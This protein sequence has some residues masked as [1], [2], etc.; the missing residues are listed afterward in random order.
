MGFIVITIDGMGS[1]LRSKAF[2]DVSYKNLGDIGAADHILAI[3]QLAQNRPYMDIEKVGI[4]GHSAG[5]YDAAHALLTHPEFYKVA[6]SIAG[7]H[8][9]MM[10]KAWWDEQYMGLPGKHY[11]E[12]SNLTL[13][14]NLQ[15]K[16]FS[17]TGDMDQNVNPA[18]TIRFAGELIKHNKD[19][20]LLIVPNADHDILYNPYVVRKMWDY[21][22]INLLKNNPPKEFNIKM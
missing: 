11:E 5:G 22:V 9:N 10:S 8:D 4:Y 18:N 12:Q 14:K 3:K 21:F 7:N 16:L 2:H 13:A 15:G 17:I 19:F 20:D 6:V 1:A